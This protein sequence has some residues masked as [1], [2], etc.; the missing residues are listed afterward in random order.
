MKHTE[1]YFPTFSR[2]IRFATFGFY[3]QSSIFRIHLSSVPL[4]KVWIIGLHAETSGNLFL[5]LERDLLL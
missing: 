1:T 5:H 4:Y 3:L 2:V